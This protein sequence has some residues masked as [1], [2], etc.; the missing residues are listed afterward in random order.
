VHSFEEYLTAAIRTAGIPSRTLQSGECQS[1]A[2]KRCRLCFAVDLTY[3]KEVALKNKA[4]Q[5]FWRDHLPHTPLGPLVVSPRGRAYRTVTKRKA[6][7]RRNGVLLGLI[8]PSEHGSETSFNVV[9]CA[10]EPEEHARIYSSIQ[11]SLGKPYATPLADVLNYA[12]IKGSYAEF[13]VILNIGDASASIIRGANT[14]SKSLTHSHKNIVGVFVYEEESHGRYYLGTKNRRVQPCL[15]KVFGKSEIY[16]RIAGRSF[17]YS[18]LSFS[19]VNQSIIETLVAQA[20]ELLDLTKTQTLYDLYCGYG[21]FSICLAGK[22][23]KIIG[24]E[25]SPQSV[26]SAEANATRNLIANA[27]FIRSDV[28]AA[29]LQR[30]MQKSTPEDVVLL[31]PP[32]N[33]TAEGVIETIA[34]RKPRRVLHLFCN[35]DLLPAELKRWKSSGYRP[36]RA[37]P[38]D[39][40]PG[41]S[42]VETV[43]VLEGRV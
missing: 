10:I 19:Q 27:R 20:A 31:D 5:Q 21:L 28:T 9:R 43:V 18:P 14:L 38:F 36:I 42:E 34:A 2:A 24:A 23:G 40:F 11:S 22:A 13:T 1:L 15:K 26:E 25:I 37:I 32:R 16:Q 3:E 41:T 6:F 12:I 4:L 8:D 39:L 35:I 29:S 30:I 33:G 7:H 17:L